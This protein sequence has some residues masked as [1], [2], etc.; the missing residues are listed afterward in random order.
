MFI[1]KHMNAVKVTEKQLEK[2]NP[3]EWIMEEKFK[4]IRCWWIKSGSTIQ[5][6]TRGGEDITSK[7]P[8]LSG[9]DWVPQATAIQLD[10]ELYDPEQEDEVVSGWAMRDTIDAENVENCVLKVFDLL[11]LQ[12]LSLATAKQLDRKKLLASLKLRGPLETTKFQPAENH[13]EYYEYITTT[14]NKFNKL[15][16]GIMLKNSNSIYYPGS[17]KVGS[18]LKRKKRDPFDCVVLGFTQAKEGKFFGL[19]GAVQVGMFVSG[20][21]RPICNVSGMSDQVRKDMTL[22]PQ[23]YIGKP[24]SIFAME[25]D[26]NSLALIE[27]S[28]K[29]LRVDIRIEDCCLRTDVIQ[30][31]EE[32]ALCEL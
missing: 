8:H 25:Q 9:I 18:W 22:N 27:P 10:C 21:L 1:E 26:R 11:N 2:L 7:F 32:D 20:V 12:G 24:C 15:G 17:R 14:K 31:P 6:I 28:W 30:E 23:N 3:A 19:I 5:M 16:E 4:G 13:R 29:G